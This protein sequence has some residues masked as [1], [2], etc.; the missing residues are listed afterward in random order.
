[1][2][3][4]M[5]HVLLGTLFLA[6]AA[7]SGNAAPEPQELGQTKFEIAADACLIT[8]VTAAVVGDDG[9]SL[10]LDGEGKGASSGIMS[11]TDIACVLGRLKVPDSVVSQMDATSALQGRQAAE[12][13]DV[14]ASWT[15]HPDNG[16]DVILTLKK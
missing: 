16:L 2:A 10:E 4:R 14:S 11:V 9:Y 3:K 13:D 1:M 12:W 5:Q 15:Y 8:D 7:C 6:V